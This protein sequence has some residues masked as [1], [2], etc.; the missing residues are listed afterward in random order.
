MERG[1]WWAAVCGVAQSQT[2]KRL[3]SSS[4]RIGSWQ[5]H[6]HVNWAGGTVCREGTFVTKEKNIPKGVS[7]V[8]LKHSSNMDKVGIYRTSECVM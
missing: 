5:E 3:S 7:K 6:P 1:A 4:S 8:K 2:L